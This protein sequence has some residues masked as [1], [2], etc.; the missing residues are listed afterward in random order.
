MY[1]LQTIYVN[2]DMCSTSKVNTFT[3][4]L[5]PFSSEIDECVGVDCGS[6][7]CEDHVGW[8]LCRC[9]DGFAGDKCQ[10]GKIR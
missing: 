7:T 10:L 6:G 8:F 1:G 5:L 2:R 3:M 9:D 4:S